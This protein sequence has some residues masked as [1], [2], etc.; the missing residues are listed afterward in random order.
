MGRS[1]RFVPSLPAEVGA[2]DSL[3][4]LSF[5]DLGE[6]A[7]QRRP[8][9]SLRRGLAGLMVLISSLMT[10][11]LVTTMSPGRMWIFAACI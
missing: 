7:S 6:L 3:E 1:Q 2:D 4:A 5:D 10:V 8:P 11:S 9:S